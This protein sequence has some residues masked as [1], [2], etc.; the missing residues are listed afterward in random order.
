MRTFA[1]QL[2][3]ASGLFEPMLHGVQL[4]LKGGVF[5]GPAE[6]G[7]EVANRGRPAAIAEGS[8]ANQ[9]KGRGAKAVVGQNQRGY[10]RRNQAPGTTEPLLQ[11]IMIGVEV[12]N[13]DIAAPGQQKVVHPF[14]VRLQKNLEVFSKRGGKKRVQRAIFRI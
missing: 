1:D 10:L 13:H 5:E 11:R 9:F 12:Q 8:G 3:A 4:L 7:L 14:L 6:H 2:I